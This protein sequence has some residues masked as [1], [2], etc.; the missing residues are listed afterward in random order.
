MRV[1]AALRLIA[2]LFTLISIGLGVLVNPWWF[3]FTAFVALNLIQSA[4]SNWCPM[5]SILKAAGVRS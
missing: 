5:M 4:F 3:A 2:G 1:E